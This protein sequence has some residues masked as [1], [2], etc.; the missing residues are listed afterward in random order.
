MEYWL[1]S[2]NEW[3]SRRFAAEQRTTMFDISAY[4]DTVDWLSKVPSIA[5]QVGNMGRVMGSTAQCGRDGAELELLEIIV[6]SKLPY[7]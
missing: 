4:G 1:Q 2:G 7:L 5:R 6:E 3:F